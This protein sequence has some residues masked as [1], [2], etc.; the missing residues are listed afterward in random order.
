MILPN[1]H[2]SPANSLIGFAGKILNFTEEPHT[3][4]QLWEKAR[5]LNEVGTFERF[6]YSLD[7]LFILGL[8]DFN[9]DMIERIK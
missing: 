4:T 7:F 9:E 3:V 8:I 6:S 5:L 2:I 1:K